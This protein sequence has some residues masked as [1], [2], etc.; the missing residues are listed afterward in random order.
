M[1]KKP[2]PY[3]KCPT[4]L[5]HH[6]E[7]PEHLRG[8]AHLAQ[9][10]KDALVGYSSAPV[11]L[12]YPLPEAGQHGRIADVAVVFPSGY[13]LVYECQLASISV[14]EISQRT[15]DYANAGVEVVWFLGGKASTP[16]IQDWCIDQFGVCYQ[17]HS[18]SEAPFVTRENEFT[19][20]LKDQ[21][22]RPWKYI[23]EQLDLFDLL[24]TSKAREYERRR[25]QV[26]EQS[27]Q[28]LEQA[29]NQT[30][31]DGSRIIGR[32]I[33]HTFYA[34]KC[35]SKEQIHRGL[36]IL[37]NSKGAQSVS[38]YLGSLNNKAIKKSCDRWVLTDPEGLTTFWHR[39][40]VPLSPQGA[41]ATK[42]RAFSLASVKGVAS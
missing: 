9:L 25:Q 6:P 36:S 37:P 21:I 42:D 29:I 19:R 22:N 3:G 11:F 38:G 24:D 26:I 5:G 31:E 34:W 41:E 30:F 15:T 27:T 40:F 14:E 4:K 8:K 23:P 28:S 18:L 7:S 16:T 10:L 33:R 2:S 1:R 39:C 20:T 12:E 13:V 32:A 35:L 17:L